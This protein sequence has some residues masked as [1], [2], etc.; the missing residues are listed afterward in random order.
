MSRRGPEH[1]ST[2]L[3]RFSRI[4][5]VRTQ[6]RAVQDAS[7]SHRED[8]QNSMIESS[9]EWMGHGGVSSFVSDAE[10]PISSCFRYS[11]VSL[12]HMVH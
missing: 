5:V 10:L 12:L 2:R 3:V 1:S 6:N 7:E 11:E 9:V 4:F 8:L